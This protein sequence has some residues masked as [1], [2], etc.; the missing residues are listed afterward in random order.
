MKFRLKITFSIILLISIFFGI[1]SSILISVSFR[2]SLEREETL[3]Q[4]SYQTILHTLLVV[5]QVDTWHNH[6]DIVSILEQISTQEQR[7]WDSLRLSS[8]QKTLYEQGNTDSFLDLSDKTDEKHCSLSFFTDKNDNHFLQLSGIIFLGEKPLTLD[9]SY[10]ISPVYEIRTQQQRIY[11]YVF[12]ILI[13]LSG[14]LAYIL[15][16]FL[17]RPLTKL[18]K[19]SKEIS[20]GNYGYRSR[21]NTRDEIGMVSR[22]FDQMAETLQT[23]ILEMELSLE[24]QKEFM[25]NFTHEMKTPM[26]SIIGYADLLRRQELSP[27]EQADAAN[28][29][30]TEGKRLE[31]LSLKL[32]DILVLDKED[33]LPTAVSPARIIR[34]LV[35]HMKPIYEKEMITLSCNCQKGTCFLEPD[36]F[37][38][39]LEN[40]LDNARK[41]F[42]RGGSISITS[43]ILPDGCLVEIQ[44][45]GRGIPKESLEHLTEAFYRIDKSRSRAL[46]GFGLGLTLCS[47]IVSLHKGTIHFESTPETGTK[48]TVILK[49]DTLCQQ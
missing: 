38:S 10:D 13:F 15:S 4:K 42:D 36:L 23:N 35:S 30:F 32:L 5:N 39:L 20:S 45:N 18:S 28:Y 44:D 47:R 33:I 37:Y 17:T 3:A 34:H 8:E 16:Y 40:L 43:K 27:E 11:S 49:G 1:G 2:N 9:V 22:D 41:S 29:I 46:G 24:R 25:G 26:T 31:R 6:Q 48:V 19:A 12:L 21:I 7:P 14:I